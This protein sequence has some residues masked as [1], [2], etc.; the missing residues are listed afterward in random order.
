[1]VDKGGAKFQK[2]ASTGDVN[3]KSAENYATKYTRISMAQFVKTMD[4]PS[5]SRHVIDETGLAGIYDFTVDISPYVLDPRT[6]KATLTAIGAID[7]ESAL[8]LALPK[9][10]GLKLERKTALVAVM[11]IDHVE[12]DPTEN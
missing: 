7:L 9:Q 8:M 6:G 5:T 1:M 2:A 10:L 11:V 12:K 4:P 3:T